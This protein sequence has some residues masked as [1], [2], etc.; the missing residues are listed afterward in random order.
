MIIL[1]PKAKNKEI[2]LTED[3]INSAIRQFICTCYPELSKG[4]LINP[5]VKLAGNATLMVTAF[6]Q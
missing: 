6:G 5:D 2:S 1:D 4:H 3:E